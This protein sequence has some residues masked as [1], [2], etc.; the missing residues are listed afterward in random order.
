MKA[1]FSRTLLRFFL[2]C[3]LAVVAPAP[4]P[5]AAGSIFADD[6]TPRAIGSM[7]VNERQ[8]LPD[9]TMVKLKSGRVASLGTLRAE[10]RA[11]MERFSRA[12][13]LGQATAAKLAAHP[14]SAVPPSP[15]TPANVRSATGAV[16]S[17]GVA[18]GAIRGNTAIPPKFDAL[19]STLVPFKFH[20]P[21]GNTP[22]DYAD[23]C[24]A[25]N[26]SVCIYLP[27]NTTFASFV[28]GSPS[29]DAMVKDI[30]KDEDPLI[31]DYSIC[32]YDG[33]LILA[34]PGE[35]P[36]G[37]EFDYPINNVVEFLPKGSVSTSVSC[38]P[39]AKYVIDPKGAVQ[40]SYP[41]SGSTFSTSATPVTCVVQ[42]W[43]GK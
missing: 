31:T 4:V 30:V 32:A 12:A 11:R 23:F 1:Y 40:A 16:K 37:C 3:V 22:R 35:T 41:F 9:G 10:H 43:V 15:P 6:Q 27:P 14:P 29:Y 7:T 8:S 5:M 18:P 13:A 19:S 28:G 36:T 34:A 38:D 25:A 17:G 2:I 26:P 42:V 24:K 39:P 33:G 21:R 20:N